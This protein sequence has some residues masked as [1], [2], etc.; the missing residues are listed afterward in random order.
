MQTVICYNVYKLFMLLRESEMLWH[1]V[2]SDGQK[3][4][5]TKIVLKNFKTIFQILK[6]LV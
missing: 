4:F 1:F 3:V 2:D 6:R 5:F